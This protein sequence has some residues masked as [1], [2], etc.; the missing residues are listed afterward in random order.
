MGHG[1]R[2]VQTAF[3]TQRRGW[4]KEERTHSNSKIF[5]V[6]LN[7]C[8]KIVNSI[9]KGQSHSLPCTSPDMSALSIVKGKLMEKH[10]C[11]YASNCSVSCSERVHH[12]SGKQHLN[13]KSLHVAVNISSQLQCTPSDEAL[14]HMLRQE[15]NFT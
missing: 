5:S 6:G 15:E 12:R 10:S 8:L 1:V 3:E 11:L 13:K 7:C 14:K 2:V 4:V 9:K